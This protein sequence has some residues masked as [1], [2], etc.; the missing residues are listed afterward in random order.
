MTDWLM[1]IAERIMVQSQKYKN[2]GCNKESWILTTSWQI[3]SI[4]KGIVCFLNLKQAKVSTL[5]ER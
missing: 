5:N 1:S 4:I 3:K 2:R